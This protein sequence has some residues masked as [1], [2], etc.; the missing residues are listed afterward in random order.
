[1][2]V[3]WI[4]DKYFSTRI[5]EQLEGEWGWDA[6]VS[7]GSNLFS[8]KFDRYGGTATIEVKNGAVSS[9]DA[10]TTWGHNKLTGQCEAGLGDEHKWVIQE[11]AIS[12]KNLSYNYSVS[13]SNES[14][15]ATAKLNLNRGQLNGH[16]ERNG[17]TAISGSVNYYK[18]ARFFD[19]R[20]VAEPLS[21]LA[22]FGLARK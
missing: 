4:G 1:M 14:G 18:N 16:F 3:V 2:V 11:V 10:T 21:W 17:Q 5:P 6:S 13:N 20:S 12:D 22:R 9:M 19:C 15:K 7:P 8:D